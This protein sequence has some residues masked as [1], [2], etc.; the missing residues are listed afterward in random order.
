MK[1]LYIFRQELFINPSPWWFI[2]Y[3]YYPV[4]SVFRAFDKDNDNKVSAEEWV[5]G[6]SIFLRGCLKESI[7]FCFDV[8]DM[9]SDGWITKE[10]M[11]HLLKFCL[12][13]RQQEEDPDEGVRDLVD[14]VLKKLVGS[15]VDLNL[16]HSGR[17]YTEKDLVQLKV[18]HY[19]A[20]PL[21]ISKV[22]T[23]EEWN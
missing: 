19:I 21:Q 15:K 22:S 13:Q 16:F 2:L 10:E 23:R 17:K 7:K 12:P 18:R 14:S 20:Y 6:L 11:F 5:K 3:Y 4:V 1:E 9:N 8:Y